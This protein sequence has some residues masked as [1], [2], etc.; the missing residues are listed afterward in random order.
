MVPRTAA[1]LALAGLAFVAGAWRTTRAPVAGFTAFAVGALGLSGLLQHAFGAGATAVRGLT[2]MAVTTCVGLLILA[3]GQGA[4]AWARGAHRPVWPAW[5]P[6]AAASGA[7]LVCG[8]LLQT[9]S[10]AFPD[11]GASLALT[12]AAF[13]GTA[14]AVLVWAS[15]GAARRAQEQAEVTRQAL[16]E[17]AASESR[18]RAIFDQSSAGIL[19][20]DT[21]GRILGA[22]QRF[23]D[24]IGRP[25]DALTALRLQDITHPEDRAEDA[26]NLARGAMNTLPREGWTKRSLRPDGRASWARVSGSLVQDPGG[27]PSHLVG[28]V[29]DITALVEIEQRLQL[30][31]TN[32][33]HGLWDWDLT[34]GHVFIDDQWAGIHGYGAGEIQPSVEAWATTLHPDDAPRVREALDRALASDDV[35]YDVD[36]RARRQDGTYVWVNSRG[37]V[38]Q[39]DAD[40]RPLR[41]MGTLHDISERKA[42]EERIRESLR[43]NEVLLKEVHHRVKNNLAAMA[44]L[45]YLQSQTTRDPAT[46]ALLEDSRARVHS[47]ALVHELLYR[48]SDLSSVDFAEYAAALADHLIKGQ[49]RSTRLH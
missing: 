19:E 45:F 42:A 5:L 18:V 38:Q 6:G 33:R 22:N 26:V 2:G 41:M 3:V 25:L 8:L 49:S 24:L 11:P 14:V 20:L 36:Y 39:R 27:A 40:G 46:L 16:L 31:L 34:T 32:A 48:G 17:Q 13:L 37:R 35:V 7:L 12:T 43:V 30:A 47:M 44:S 21:A 9:L 23:C 15:L 10:L 1:A 4:D 29:Q 28:V